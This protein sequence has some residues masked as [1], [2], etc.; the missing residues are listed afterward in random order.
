MLSKSNPLLKLY[1]VE[2]AITNL[3][4]QRIAN[5]IM[6][7]YK[8]EHRERVIIPAPCSCSVCGGR[9]ARS[10]RI[11]PRYWKSSRANGK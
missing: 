7:L 4:A 1:I 9:L 11:P 3:V 2:K 8:R 6:R 10:A 5:Y